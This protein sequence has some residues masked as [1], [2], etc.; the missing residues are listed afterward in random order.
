MID[1]VNAFPMI[2]I[3]GLLAKMV[4]KGFSAQVVA[5]IQGFLSERWAAVRWQG[6]VGKWMKMPGAPQGL[7]LS[8]LLFSIFIDD[9]LEELAGVPGLE[10]GGFADDVVFGTRCVKPEEAEPVLQAGLEIVERWALRWRQQVSREKTVQTWFSRDNHQ[11]TQG[12]HCELWWGGWLETEVPAASFADGTLT[13]SWCLDVD[14]SSEGVWEPMRGRTVTHLDGVRVRDQ[15]EVEAFLANAGGQVR[16]RMRDKVRLD[17]FP[18]YLGVVLDPQLKFGRAGQEAYRAMKQRLGSLRKLAG[19]QYGCSTRALRAAYCGFVRSKVEYAGDTVLTHCSARRLQDLEGAQNEAARVIT[20]CTGDTRSELVRSEAGLPKLEVRARA[21]AAMRLARAQRLPAGVPLRKVAEGPVTSEGWLAT[22]RAALWEAGVLEAECEPIVTKCVTVPGFATQ[23]TFTVEYGEARART[24][25]ARLAFEAEQV[26]Q[27]CRGWLFTDGG[28]ER[29]V[30]KGGSGA[31]FYGEGGEALWEGR[32]AAGEWCSSFAAEAVALRK[33][34][35]CVSRMVESGGWQ[36]AKVGVALD[37]QSLLVRL[38]EGPGV[39]QEVAGVEIWRLIAQLE[40]RW[41]VVLCLCWCPGHTGVAGNERADE[42]AT[43]GKAM[44]QQAVPLSLSTCAMA[45]QAKVR[46]AMEAELEGGEADKVRYRTIRSHGK[47]AGSK[48]GTRRE[49]RLLCQLR[50]GW[51]P[52]CRVTRA[53]Y[54]AQLGESCERC[55]ARESVDHLLFS[56]PARVA[57]RGKVWGVDAEPDESW[58]GKHP[59]RVLA[60]IRAGHL[61]EEAGL[62]AV[63]LVLRRRDRAKAKAK[64][65]AKGKA[66]AKAKAKVRG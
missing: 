15:E 10:V 29:G 9:L 44:S 19:T 37:S 34:L 1:L 7:V 18:K 36:G 42:L 53:K 23:C 40:Q 58:L 32:W 51:S 49:D 55:G 57:L 21:K 61:W 63:G 28:A 59:E 45:V 20:G 62:D 43:L 30:V 47:V 14:A 24:E 66:K 60:L 12:I 56:C 50:V 25:E 5:W 26:R 2:W 65:G 31:V 3:D 16:V 8:P 39:Q 13:C 11:M 52:L 35:V 17:Q 6:V 27:E 38:A 22:A 46:E 33:A 48:S 64:A 54:D 4:K 41:G